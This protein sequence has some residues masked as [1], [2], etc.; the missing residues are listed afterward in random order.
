MHAIYLLQADVNIEVCCNSLGQVYKGHF[1][2]PLHV[3]GLYQP[4]VGLSLLV[5]TAGACHWPVCVHPC[6]PWVYLC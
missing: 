6:L 4:A 1:S 2:S 5:V 3:L